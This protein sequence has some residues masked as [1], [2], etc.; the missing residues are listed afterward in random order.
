MARHAAP[1]VAVPTAPSR[2]DRPSSIGTT[3]HRA[4]GRRRT[5]MAVGRGQAVAHGLLRRVAKS[6]ARS[7]RH[8]AASLSRVS[9]R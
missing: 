8:R 7:Y 3:R 2:T 6:A 1:A 9:F 4:A 5:T